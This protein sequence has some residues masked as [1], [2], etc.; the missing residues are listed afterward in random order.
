MRKEFLRRQNNRRAARRKEK[1]EKKFGVKTSTRL[2]GR[3]EKES[4]HE[5]DFDTRQKKSLLSHINYPNEFRKATRTRAMAQRVGISSKTG[6]TRCEKCFPI[7][8][9][10]SCRSEQR[11]STLTSS[12]NYKVG[13]QSRI[14]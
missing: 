5:G 12:K 9:V 7:T 13:L 8:A 14:G 11:R 3:M 1:E 4:L 6:F 10:I 2:Y